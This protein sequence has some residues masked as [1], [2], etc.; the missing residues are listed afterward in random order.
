M[1]VRNG[2]TESEQVNIRRHDVNSCWGGE[3]SQYMA[4]YFTDVDLAYSLV[5]DLVFQC[6]TNQN[7][8]RFCTNEI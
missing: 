5:N 1:Q 8:S 2:E 6:L 4:L 7:I 3:G